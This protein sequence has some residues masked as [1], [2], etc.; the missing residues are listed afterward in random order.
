MH[1]GNIA[2]Q[3]SYAAP[4]REQVTMFCE[5]EVE[6]CSIYTYKWFK[7]NVSIFD[8]SLNT[9]SSDY[10]VS[11]A[12]FSLQITDLEFG[13]SEIY[14]CQLLVLGHNEPYEGREVFIEVYG[15]CIY[16]WHFHAHI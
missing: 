16:T 1:A 3:T 2:A 14:H 7:E 9:A 6:R 10:V 12:D 8:S 4:I 15:T 13:D 11:D 5:Y